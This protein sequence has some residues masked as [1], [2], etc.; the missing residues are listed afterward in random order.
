MPNR[1]LLRQLNVDRTTSD[2][3][4]TSSFDATKEAAPSSS[5]TGGGNRLLLLVKRIGHRRKID[6][7]KANNA[8]NHIE[9]T[10]DDDNTPFNTG[11]LQHEYQE[12][13]V[14]NDNNYDKKESSQNIPSSTTDNCVITNVYQELHVAPLVRT[15]NSTDPQQ[16]LVTMPTASPQPRKASGKLFRMITRQIGSSKVSLQL[17]TKSEAANS[18]AAQQSLKSDGDTGEQQQLANLDIASSDDYEH[19]NVDG[20]QS[21]SE[22]TTDYTDSQKT[23]ST[24]SANPPAGEADSILTDLQVKECQQPNHNNDCK[25]PD[26]DVFDFLPRWSPI[27]E[28]QRLQEHGW[29]WGPLSRDEANIKLAGQPDGTFLVRDCSHNKCCFC[30][31][32]RE[33][34]ETLHILIESEFQN[35]YKCF[36]LNRAQVTARTVTGLIDYHLSNSSSN[37][38]RMVTSS[39]RHIYIAFLKSLSRFNQVSSL[40]HLCRFVVRQHVRIDTLDALPLPVSIKGWLKLYPY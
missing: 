8:D 23:K 3:T 6:D 4:M 37:P 5:S 30:I 2:D 11:K 38:I 26:I 9:T 1:L 27:E 36:F 32:V 21:T 18:A 16:T 13:E 35:G 17:L 31:S 24:N 22:P 10:K 7:S 14:V 15:L 28:L 40:Q 39:G 25:Q 20:A 12:M 33:N 34:D 29:Y 19:H